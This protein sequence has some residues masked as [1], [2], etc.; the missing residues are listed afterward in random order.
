MREGGLRVYTTI[1]PRLQRDAEHAIQNT[2][3]EPTD[4]ASALVAIDPR[5]RRDPGDER[6]HPGQ[7]GN[8]FNLAVQAR[9]QPGSTF[10][11]FVL[12]TAVAKG[13]DP[14]GQLLRLGAVRVPAGPAR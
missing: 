14:V 6:G 10:K 5:D 13:I 11:T 4:P 2:L 3:N 12:T 9:R 8:Q 1:D 7:E